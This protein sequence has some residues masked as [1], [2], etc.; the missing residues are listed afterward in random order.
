MRCQEIYERISRADAEK[1]AEWVKQATRD[2]ECDEAA[3]HSMDDD[4]WL[5]AGDINDQN[6][7]YAQE[8]RLERLQKEQ[9]KQILVKK[10]G[11]KVSRK[12]VDAAYDQYKRRQH[13]IL[14][15]NRKK[16]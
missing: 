15:K 13:E 12:D 6:S 11:T 1:H 9:L 10:Y 4:E 2:I 7:H 8:D 16:H 3:R 5:R 14:L